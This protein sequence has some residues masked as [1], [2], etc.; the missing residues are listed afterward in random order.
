M[1][2]PTVIADMEFNTID[3]FQ[4]REVDILILSTV[5]AAESCSRVDGL[6][7]SSIGFVADTR[8]MN[9]ALTRAKHSLW[10]FGNARTLLGN[11]NWAALVKDAKERNLVI[12]VK[13][14]YGQFK[15]VSGENA[16][17]EESK[18]HSIKAKHVENVHCSSKHSKE[19]Q[20]KFQTACHG[21]TEDKTVAVDDKK[22]EDELS[23]RKG[24][25]DDSDRK[26][27]M[28]KDVIS[29]EAVAEDKSM[30]SE[31]SKK[32]LE[33]FPKKVKSS[34]K[35]EKPAAKKE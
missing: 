29:K 19:V 34:E 5:R 25:R 2:G 16:I 33:K 8:R 22:N 28:V 3:G 10:I 15:K 6:N 14:P 30:C 1:F 31:R 7:S 20:Q 23:S 35:H 11:F 24:A 32:K 21:N 13:R 27:K 26:I 17:P 12:S 4:G 9:V 18:Y